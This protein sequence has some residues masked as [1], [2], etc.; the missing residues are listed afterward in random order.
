[1]RTGQ[2]C[3]PPQGVGQCSKHQQHTLG[4]TSYRDPF[5]KPEFCDMSPQGVL[6][7]RFRCSSGPISGSLRNPLPLFLDANSEQSCRFPFPANLQ[8]PVGVV[9]WEHYPR[10]W[11]DVRNAYSVRAGRWT[12]GSRPSFGPKFGETLAPSDTANQ[13]L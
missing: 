13:L 6:L 9:P 4:E 7:Q 1:M 11:A 10:R 3:R 2:L 8:V 5:G 12:P